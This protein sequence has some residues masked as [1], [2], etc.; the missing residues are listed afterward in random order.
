MPTLPLF[1]GLLLLLLSLHTVPA[2]T[3]AKDND[4]LLP[5]QALAV[6][7]KLVSS[8]GKF[9]LGF[10][11]PGAAGNISKSSTSPGWYL[12]IWFNK[13][14]LLTPVWVANRER[15]IAGPDLRATQLQISGDG[16]LVVVVSNQATQSV[17]WSTDIANNN[18]SRPS[19]MTTSAAVLLG[20]GNLVVQVQDPSPPK[21]NAVLW[22]SFDDPTDVA[23]PGAKIGWNKVTGLNRVGVSWRSR[24]DPGLG[25]FSVGLETNGTRRVMVS[26]RVHPSKV[27]WSWSPVSSPM[28]IPALKAL[29]RMNPQT[30]GLVV[31]EYVDNDEEEY[32]MYTSPDESSSTFLSLD[33][34]GQTKMNVW[35]PADQAWHSIYVQPVD[36]CRPYA[37]CGPFAVCTGSSNQPCE[38][39]ETFSRTSPPDWELGDRTRGCS[40]STPLDCSGNRSSSSASTDVF[41]PMESVTLP[42]GP[43]S[44]QDAATRSECERACRSNCSCTAYSIQGSKCS[45]WHGELFSVNKN[46][47][48]E[49]SAED[50]LY[51]RLAA[52]DFPTAASRGTRRPSVAGV[53]IAASVAGFGLLM[54]I[55]LLLLMIS[56]NRFNWCGGASSHATGHGTVGVVAFRYSDL[57]RATRNFSEKLGAGGFGSV[58]K[59]VLSDLTRVAVKRLDG[60]R[61]Q[62][63]K[64]FRAEVGALGQI[65]HINLVKLIGFCCQGDSKRLLVYEHMCNGSLDSHLFQSKGRTV[66][67]WRTRFQIAIGVARGLS[68]LHQS[69]RECII[70][71]DIKPENVL[72]DESF[73]PKIADFGLASVVGRDFSRVLT[74]FRGTMGYLAPEWLSGVA[75]TSKVDVYSFGMV[76]MEIVSGRR[77]AASA[78]HTSGSYCVAY[79]PVQAISKLH[80]GDVQSLVDPELRG[81]FSLD[82]AERVCKIACWCIQDSES[83]RPTMGEVVRVLEGLQELDMPPMPRLLAAITDSSNVDSMYSNS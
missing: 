73:V 79:F 16:N 8:N 13:I 67:D 55:M 25:A 72:L 51:I 35:S 24:T 5:G 59:G 61:H 20:S 75:I 47:G 19:N 78:D 6:G 68:Y 69:C 62:G 4:T 39:M 14:P 2:S 83:D 45:V 64:Q 81:D 42:Y 40:R 34:S 31:P 54:L 82:E 7:E 49:I 27:Y 12:A 63:E 10:F 53:A 66:L 58:F 36:P 32:Y 1:L 46:D 18:S 60:A 70:H 38:C 21:S 30:R 17:V 9:A 23:L 76:L 26:R 74:T 80:E 48:I 44:V 65:Q 22:Q 29:L 3:A 77:N 71:C 15:P 33:T 28:Q 11:Q 52:G 37:T 50:T 56:R 43:Q 41:H 57:C